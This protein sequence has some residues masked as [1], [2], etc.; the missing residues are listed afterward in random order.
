M[1][2]VTITLPDTIEKSLLKQAK[3]QKLAPE[4]LALRILE[5][6]L[7]PETELEVEDFAARIKALPP[8]PNSIRPATESLQ[9]LLQNAPYDPEF[10]LAE[11]QEAWMAVEAEMKE[12]TRM[13]CAMI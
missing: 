5:D 1:M 11:W 4:E 10:D 3:K 2:T 9:K 13:R 8:N 6:A 7:V 12:M